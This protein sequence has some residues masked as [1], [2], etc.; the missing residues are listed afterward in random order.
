MTAEQRVTIVYGNMDWFDVAEQPDGFEDLPKEF[1]TAY[2]LWQEDPEKNYDKMVELLQPY[3]IAYFLPGNINDWEELFVDPDGEGS[4]EF[5]PI[6]AR[7]V[8]LDFVESP[9]PM[10]KAEAL[11]RVPVTEAFA[12]CDDFSEWQDEH[13]YFYGG[14]SFGWEIPRTEATEDLDLTYGDHSGC[15]C[16]VEYQIG[17]QEWPNL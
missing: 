11:F 4:P 16:M 15:E 7:I 2:Q 6:S 13:D 17:D 1:E 10:C 9:I 3:L 12:Q 5:T 14:V 8:G